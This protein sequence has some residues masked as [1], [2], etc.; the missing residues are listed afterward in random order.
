MQ[1][2]ILVCGPVFC[3]LIFTGLPEFP[4]LGKEIFAADLKLSAGG[5]AIVAAG[6]HRLGRKVGLV[7]SL[8][9]DPISDLLWQLLGELGLDRSLITRHPGA[10][11]QLTVGLSYPHDRAFITRFEH[12]ASPPDL[13]S[14]LTAH[15]A[16]HL[17]LCSYLAALEVPDA[18]RLAHAAGMSVSLDPGWDEH[19]LRD[20]SLLALIKDLDFFMP[21]RPELELI[22]DSEDCGQAAGAL[23]S[24]MGHGRIVMKNGD[25]GASLYSHD[26][27]ENLHL[28]ALPVTV[29]DT[30]GAG[31][32]F[33]AGFL[34]ACVQGLPLKD[35]MQYGIICGSLAVTASGG[36]AG[37]PDL[38]EVNQWLSKLES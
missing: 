22:A 2:D 5:S 14:I 19:A 7:A 11:H 13:A 37:I 8:G 1:Y 30:T 9:S 25:R 10:L 17:H 4:A 32:A 29:V 18:C 21:N 16:R 36:T 31:D 12:P 38:E 33:D 27:Q 6:I 26:S 23:L 20:P 15:P 34:S 28:P 35:C 3:D 24:R